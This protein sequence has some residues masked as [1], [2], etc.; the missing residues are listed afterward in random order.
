MIQW[1]SLRSSCSFASLSFC[2]AMQKQ[3]KRPWF[4]SSILFL[5]PLHTVTGVTAPSVML[6]VSK[7]GCWAGL[8][9]SRGHRRPRNM[10]LST[11]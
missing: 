2:L 6:S 9:V 7:F 4:L 1:T 11:A 3:P 10:R 8:A 5:L